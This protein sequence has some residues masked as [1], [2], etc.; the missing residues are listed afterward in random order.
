MENEEKQQGRGANVIFAGSDLS[1]F[2]KPSEKEADVIEIN[3]ITKLGVFFIF[4]GLMFMI[5]VGIYS[6]WLAVDTAIAEDAIKSIV[7]EWRIRAFLIGLLLTIF[8]ASIIL[9][10]TDE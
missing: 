3:W 6:I 9:D 1:E 7:L 10:T 5:A 2:N 4:V 8:G